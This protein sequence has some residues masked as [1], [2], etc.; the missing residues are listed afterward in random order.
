MKYA[1]LALISAAALSLAACDPAPKRDSADAEQ[2]AKDDSQAGHTEVQALG[3]LIV[4]EGWAR[5][6][7]EGAKVGGAFLTIVNGTHNGDALLSASANFADEVQIHRTTEEDGVAKMAQIKEHLPVPAGATLKLRPGGLH[8]MFFGL[9]APLKAGDVKLVRLQ[10]KKA[11]QK[12]V[13]IIVR[14]MAE[15]DPSGAPAMKMEGHEGHGAE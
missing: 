14:S 3:E 1:S 11:G 13:P 7:A 9:K 8:L 4:A 15:G 2:S 10:F 6:T 5:E 12:T